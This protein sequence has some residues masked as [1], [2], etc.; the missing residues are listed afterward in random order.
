MKILQTT[1]A[2]AA[3]LGGSAI[4][5]SAD[6]SPIYLKVAAG[7]TTNGA[8]EGINLND[9]MAY[10]GAIGTAVGPVRLE[11]GATHV[12]G[13]IAGAI[14]LSG[15]DYSVRGMLDFPLSET[16]GVFVGGG[17]DYIDGS[18]N[19]GGSDLSASGYGWSY[20]A[21]VAHRFAPNLVGEISYTHTSADL[22]SPYGS[23][24]VEFDTIMAGA[25]WSL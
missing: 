12:A 23:A 17:G 24:N 4:F 21:G 14:N 8:I 7:Q 16:T 1:A 6:A 5:T 2:L 11:V 15:W 20:V 3:L 22:D 10:E 25:R 9:D 18:A 13:N 19:F